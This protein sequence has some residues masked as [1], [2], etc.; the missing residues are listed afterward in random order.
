M[1]DGD[2]VFTCEPLYEN[3]V[4][5]LRTCYSQGLPW[6][7]VGNF[8]S[9]NYLKSDLPR[10]SQWNDLVAVGRLIYAI[11][12]QQSNRLGKHKSKNI[13]S[14]LKFSMSSCH[15]EKIQHGRF[16]RNVSCT[17]L[18]ASRMLLRGGDFPCLVAQFVGIGDCAVAFCLH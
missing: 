5:S 9:R 10:P 4:T 14:V 11:N 3:L 6:K 12:K 18:L 8:G 1:G 7:L 13:Y 17:V 16:W 15:G 2:S